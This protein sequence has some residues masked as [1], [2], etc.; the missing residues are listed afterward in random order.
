M[1]ETKTIHQR[2]PMQE[3]MGLEDLLCMIGTDEH[4]F[5]IIF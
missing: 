5:W 4:A 1:G 3:E 2:E